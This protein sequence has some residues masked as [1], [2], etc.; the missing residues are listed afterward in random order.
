MKVIEGDFL[1]NS[2]TVNKRL[3]GKYVIEIAGEKFVL[4]DDIT[5]LVVLN[6]TEDRSFWKMLMIILLGV[7]IIGLIIAIPWLIV[8]K[9]HGATIGVQTRSGRKFVFVADNAT[10]RILKNYVGIG[11][12]ASW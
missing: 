4:P 10:W 12:A 1:N 2:V 5:R 11:A 3:F 6:K 9:K 8:S 7:T